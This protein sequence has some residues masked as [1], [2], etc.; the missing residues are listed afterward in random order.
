MKFHEALNLLHSLYSESS[1]SKPW[2]P[3]LTPKVYGLVD[4]KSLRPSFT[5]RGQA[6]TFIASCWCNVRLPQATQIA[7]RMTQQFFPL[8]L[9]FLHVTIAFLHLQGTG[10]SLNKKVDRH[11]LTKEPFFF[12]L[13]RERIHIISTASRII[14]SKAR[15][16]RSC[17]LTK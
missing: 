8:K 6:I 10:N 16:S 7:G 1:V 15:L 3:V 5:E 17:I 12:L 2:S 13:I 4:S 11:N 14:L 9:Q